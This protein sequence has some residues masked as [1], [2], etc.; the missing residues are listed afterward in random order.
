[1]W[2][3]ETEELKGGQSTRYILTAMAYCEVLEAWRSERAFQKFYSELLAASPYEAYTW[4]LPPVSGRTLDIEFE[5]V[6]TDTP[7]LLKNKATPKR[8]VN[9]FKKLP[10]N[11][12]VVTFPNLSGDAVMVVPRQAGPRKRF[13]SHLGVFMR[14]G[15]EE[16]RYDFWKALSE[17]VL[18][19]VSLKP[20]WV[21][22]SGLGVPWLHGR[23]DSKP[24]YYRHSDYREF[25]D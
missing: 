16:Q 13:Y 11:K 20:I 4:E 23:I 12:S 15:P 14:Q 1:M 2:K 3:V 21:S 24:K 25:R 8:F 17:A 5:F 22:T 18:Q 7:I 10:Q 19:Q 6:L 9:Q